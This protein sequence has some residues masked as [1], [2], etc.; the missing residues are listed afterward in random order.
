MS[1]HQSIVLTKIARKTIFFARNAVLQLKKLQIIEPSI[2][3]TTSIFNS[4]REK[5]LQS[6][7]HIRE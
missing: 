7:L 4:T 1:T 5:I 3:P 6:S 2:F